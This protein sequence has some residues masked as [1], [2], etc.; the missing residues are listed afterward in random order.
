MTHNAKAYCPVRQGELSHT[1]RRVGAL[2][3]A[4][5]LL[6]LLFLNRKTIFILH[7]FS[8]SLHSVPQESHYQT[9]N[10]VEKHVE[11]FFLYM[12]LYMKSS[13]KIILQMNQNELNLY[14]SML[15]PDFL[16][17]KNQPKKSG[18]DTGN[19]LVIGGLI[20]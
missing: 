1:P 17:L 12:L 2:T 10:H 7:I 18:I 14:V 9:I 20:H 3:K 4:S 8:T 5:M 11:H 6:L 16:N 19:Q 15:I 13:C